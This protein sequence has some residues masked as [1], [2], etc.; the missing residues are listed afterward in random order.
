MFAQ[1]IISTWVFESIFITKDF[2]GNFS[3]FWQPLYIIALKR[4]HTMDIFLIL[5]DSLEYETSTSKYD[6]H[7]TNEQPT[8]GVVAGHE[9]NL[10]IH[11]VRCCC[12]DS[13]LA[14]LNANINLLYACLPTNQ[15]LPLGCW[16]KNRTWALTV[17]GGGVGLQTAAL[18]LELP[19]DCNAWPDLQ[20]GEGRSRTKT[21]V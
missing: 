16:T 20:T 21:D 7:P 11:C 4:V 15:Q 13:F 5:Y 10:V 1:K 19:G 6:H 14:K 3:F 9:H 18:G 8:M 17:C 2:Y 12:H